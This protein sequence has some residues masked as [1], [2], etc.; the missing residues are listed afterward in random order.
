MR[1]A[2]SHTRHAAVVSRYCRGRCPTHPL[3]SW[4]FIRDRYTSARASLATHTC[5]RGHR[6]GRGTLLHRSCPGPLRADIAP[7][8]RRTPG[9]APGAG[10]SAC[11]GPSVQE[12]ARARSGW[13]LPVRSFAR[14]H[15][16]RPDTLRRHPHNAACHRGSPARGSRRLSSSSFSS[17]LTSP[18]SALARS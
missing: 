1:H 9:C 2:L 5:G 16:F 6:H 15:C 7:E 11:H 13:S 18:M 8:R 14:S 17:S 4:R 3:D 10:V 12:R